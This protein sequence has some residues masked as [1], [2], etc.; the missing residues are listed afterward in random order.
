MPPARLKVIW[1]RA[2]DVDKGERRW[3]S[4]VAVAYVRDTPGAR[5]ADQVFE[6]LIPEDCACLGYNRDSGVTTIYDLNQLADLLGLDKAVLVEHPTAFRSGDD[7]IVP[8]PTTKLIAT[9]AARL[10]PDTVMEVVVTEE[11]KALREAMH[12]YYYRSRGHREPSHIAA[13][14]C[15]ETDAEYGKPTRAV[16]R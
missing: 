9:T 8:W 2:A 13:E 15:R 7:W 16:L 1:D 10:H 6:L 5:A 3:N 12:G 4:V 14:I 11:R